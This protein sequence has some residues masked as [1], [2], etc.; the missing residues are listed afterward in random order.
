LTAG[1]A[2]ELAATVGAKVFHRS[3]AVGAES[4]FEAAD[5]GFAVGFEAGGATHAVGFEFQGHGDGPYRGE[6]GVDASI[7]DGSGLSQV[8]SG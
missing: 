2:N 4:T 5:E 8:Q 7:A 3:R 1:T 6:I